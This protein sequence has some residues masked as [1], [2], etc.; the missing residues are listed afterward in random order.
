MK[1]PTDITLA[2]A[3]SQPKSSG[4]FRDLILTSLPNEV[5][6]ALER[7][8][9]RCCN[10]SVPIGTTTSTS[11]FTKVMV[12]LNEIAVREGRIQSRYSSISSRPRLHVV[13]SLL[14]TETRTTKKTSHSCFPMEPPGVGRNPKKGHLGSLFFLRNMRQRCFILAT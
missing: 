2:R 9:P 11:F 5:H 8:K 1:Q 7:D 6:P 12:E 3:I 4:T 14:A 10:V 13:V